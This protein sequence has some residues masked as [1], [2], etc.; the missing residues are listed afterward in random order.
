[1]WDFNSH[2]FWLMMINY[3]SKCLNRSCFYIFSTFSFKTFVDDI[4]VE[5]KV[6]GL[7]VSIA[8]CFAFLVSIEIIWFF[9]QAHTIYSEKWWS[10]RG[11]I[12][13]LTFLTFITFFSYWLLVMKE[14]SLVNIQKS[15]VITK[16][17]CI[18]IPS[19]LAFLKY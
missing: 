7:L 4:H 6:L 16:S 2:L 8:F 3:S 13:W 18:V 14:F 17:C 5:T 11:A 1:M 15:E 9:P 12:I 19:A 10:V